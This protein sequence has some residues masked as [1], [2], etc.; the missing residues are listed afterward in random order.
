MKSIFIFSLKN[1]KP[2]VAK[3][4]PDEKYTAFTPIDYRT[5][6]Q[7]RY[8]MVIYQYGVDFK[9]TWWIYKLIKYEGSLWFLKMT[10]YYGKI[11]SCKSRKSSINNIYIRNLWKCCW[12]SYHLQ[13]SKWMPK[14]LM[15]QRHYEEIWKI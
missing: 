12:N 4:C 14:D 3:N 13:C 15:C 11:L 6:K 1:V 7:F 2:S 10:L 8:C 9:L 5:Q